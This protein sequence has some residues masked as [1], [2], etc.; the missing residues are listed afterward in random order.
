MSVSMSSVCT[1]SPAR[2]IGNLPPFRQLDVC[3]GHSYPVLLYDIRCL[4][5]G[6]CG[7][8]YGHGQ[9][10]REG[11]DCMGC[12]SVG[13]ANANE[14][15]GCVLYVHT[16]GRRCDALRCERGS[17]GYVH[18]FPLL[19][20]RLLSLLSSIPSTYTPPLGNTTVRYG[21]LKPKYTV[22]TVVV[23]VLYCTALYRNKRVQYSG[24]PRQGP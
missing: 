19:S 15:E 10:G 2:P 8:T 12:R 6:C 7:N 14:R 9:G 21:Y 23:Y 20:H 22:R 11:G 3:G 16:G 1:A 13:D 18:F 4:C 17:E 5:L 24:K